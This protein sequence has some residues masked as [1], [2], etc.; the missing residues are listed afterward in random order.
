MAIYSKIQRLKK[1]I[2]HSGIDCA[3]AKT[4]VELQNEYKS[5]QEALGLDKL[6]AWVPADQKEDLR[7]QLKEI[8][9]EY[10]EGLGD[11]EQ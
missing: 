2:G 9:D 6:T 7:A 1:C 5:R 10:L 3:M 4:N 8:R 11:D